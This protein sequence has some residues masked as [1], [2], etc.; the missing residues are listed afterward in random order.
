M[1]IQNHPKRHCLRLS[2][3]VSS[4]AFVALV[5][6][7]GADRPVLVDPSFRPEL[8]PAREIST[9]FVGADGKVLVATGQGGLLVRLNHDG[10]LDRSFVFTPLPDE[11]I[12]V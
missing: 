8:D 2:P 4:L 5:L 10:T 7:Q 1:R 12:E 9:V 6:A 11:R 3:I